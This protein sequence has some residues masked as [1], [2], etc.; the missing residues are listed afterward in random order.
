MKDNESGRE[1]KIGGTIDQE[2]ERNDKINTQTKSKVQ[3]IA[4]Q[5]EEYPFLS[6][7]TL[8]FLHF[9]TKNKLYFP[10]GKNKASH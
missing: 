10:K 1:R 8:F 6:K 9:Y 3:I 7:S 5:I 4:F 2:K